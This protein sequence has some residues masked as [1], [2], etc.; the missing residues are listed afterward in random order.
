VLCKQQLTQ[1]PL[2]AQHQEAA[3]LLTQVILTS[4]NYSGLIAAIRLIP[5][6]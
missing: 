2:H 6:P 4:I 1:D 5:L 3:G